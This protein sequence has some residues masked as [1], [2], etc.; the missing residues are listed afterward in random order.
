MK[1]WTNGLPGATKR[2]GA[3]LALGGLSGSESRMR[4]DTHDGP[5][6]DAPLQRPNTLLQ[7]SRSSILEA[8]L[9]RAAGPYI[10][11]FAA[12]RCGGAFLEAIRGKW[13]FPETVFPTLQ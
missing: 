1:R 6:H 7:L 12:A 4:A 5:E 9:Y 11:H 13:R 8:I 10:W 3:N 2:L